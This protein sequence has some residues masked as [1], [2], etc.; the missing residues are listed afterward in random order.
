MNNL[1]PQIKQNSS[2]LALVLLFALFIFFLILIPIFGSLLGKVISSPQAAI[3]IT[4][5]IQDVFVFIFPAII[6]AMVSSRL[7]ARLLGIETKP[8]AIHILLAIAAMIVSVPAMNLIISWNESLHLPE[9][10]SAIEQAMRQLEDNAKNATDLLM[11]GA[12]VWSML[13]SVLIVGVLAGFSEEI[14]FRGAFQRIL[15]AGKVNGHAAV[16]TVAIIFSLFHFQMFGFVPRMLLGAF[17]GYLLW[18]TNSLW[19]PIIAHAFNNSIVVYTTWRVANNP[20]S[21]LAA[22]NDTNMWSTT[23]SAIVGAVVSVLLTTII[24]RVLHNITHKKK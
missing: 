23:D 18:W 16:W 19:V 9:S 20:D 1:G 10:L 17:F 15:Q 24:L 4:M 5:V 13:V 8:D 14:F 2:T 3:R 7:P 22:L 6:V 12:S 21:P 11:Q